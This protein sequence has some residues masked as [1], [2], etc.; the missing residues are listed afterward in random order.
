MNQKAAI[1]QLKN[2]ILGEHTIHTQKSTETKNMY[3]KYIAKL[4]IILLL[5]ETTTEIE[6]R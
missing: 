3:L 2:I 1:R 6:H 5:N 4:I